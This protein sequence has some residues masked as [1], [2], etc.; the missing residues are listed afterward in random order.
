MK[1][2]E[3]IIIEDA[4]LFAELKGID[5]SEYDLLNVESMD[6][7]TREMHEHKIRC[8]NEARKGVIDEIVNN[9][10][11]YFNT[12]GGTNEVFPIRKAIN[13]LKNSI[14]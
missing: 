9:I 4:A 6:E 1:S 8:I 13:E 3:Q 11:K 12:H 2:A 5:L 7:E 10:D 14:K